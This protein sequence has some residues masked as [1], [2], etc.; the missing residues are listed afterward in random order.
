[1]L[2]PCKASCGVPYIDTEDPDCKLRPVNVPGKGSYVRMMEHNK[3]SRK[4]LVIVGTIGI[5]HG[6]Q[7]IRVLTAGTFP[8]IDKPIPDDDFE[9]VDAGDMSGDLPVVSGGIPMAVDEH[10]RC[11][12]SECGAFV[13]PK[14][15]D[16]LLN[17]QA[18]RHDLRCLCTR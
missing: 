5:P 4:K 17:S 2:L 13:A 12:A 16:S 15:R 6:Q 3:G 9:E 7:P 11:Q 1:M 10:R 14:C 8:A 18:L